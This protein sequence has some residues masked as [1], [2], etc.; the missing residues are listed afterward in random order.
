[1]LKIPKS[2]EY[3]VLSLKY[4]SEHNDH[5]T[6]KEIADA[7]NIPFDLLAKIL[8]KLNRNEIIKS[9]QGTKGG[10]FLNNTSD[11]ISL[12]LII[13][14]VEHKIQLTDCLVEKPSTDACKRYDNCCLVN[15]LNKIQLK[16][17]ELFENTTLQEIVN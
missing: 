14:A 13:E 4:I 6:A 8:Q 11:N 7:M 15:P 12:K 10:Y 2:V 17:I 3:A 16:I 1:M 9:V 5:C